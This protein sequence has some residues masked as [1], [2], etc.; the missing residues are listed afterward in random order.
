MDGENATLKEN[1][2]QSLL[3]GAELPQK[4]SKISYGCSEKNRHGFIPSFC[5]LPEKNTQKLKMTEALLHLQFRN[6]AREI[7]AAHQ[8]FWL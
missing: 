8:T 7:P 3:M 6:K 4:S 5:M 2:K 1:W